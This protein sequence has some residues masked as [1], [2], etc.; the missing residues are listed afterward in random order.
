MGKEG[1]PVRHRGG[2]L[3]RGGQWQFVLFDAFPLYR[4]A[5]MDGMGRTRANSRMGFTTTQLLLSMQNLLGRVE[6]V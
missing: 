4:E 3:V 1:G 2:W 6:G 5:W